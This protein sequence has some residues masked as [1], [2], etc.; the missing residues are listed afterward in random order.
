MDKQ[1]L[2]NLVHVAHGQGRGFAEPKTGNAEHAN[3]Q[4]VLGGRHLGREAF[5]DCR[6]EVWS[7]MAF[8]PRPLHTGDRVRPDEVVPHGGVKD[9]LDDDRAL[10]DP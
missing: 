5:D 4:A 10:P 3:Q 7:F 8:E 1:A 6:L 9:H 2:A